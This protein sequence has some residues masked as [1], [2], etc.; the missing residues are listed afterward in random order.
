MRARKKNICEHAIVCVKIVAECKEYE[1]LETVAYG[2]RRIE[3][4]S[5]FDTSIAMNSTRNE[6]KTEEVD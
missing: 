6:E 2:I 3:Y 5:L 1:L 4:S